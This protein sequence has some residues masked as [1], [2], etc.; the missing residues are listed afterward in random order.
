MSAA[1]RTDSIMPW[2]SPRMASDAY[3][4]L[5][6]LARSCADQA[7]VTAT[8][9]VARQLW[10]MAVE[11]QQKAAALDSGRCPNIGEAPPWFEAG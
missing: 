7:R 6:E 5:A 8:R 10:G 11:F 4:H 9:D 2:Q 3:R 1:G